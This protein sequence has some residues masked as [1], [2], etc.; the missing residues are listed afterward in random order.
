MNR[1]YRCLQGDRTLQKV[2]IDYEFLLKWESTLSAGVC[3]E[4]RGQ[5]SVVNPD[6]GTQ[7]PSDRRK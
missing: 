6:R 4:P 1:R 7:T 5:L 2:P 3:N